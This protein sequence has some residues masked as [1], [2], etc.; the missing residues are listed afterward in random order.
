[1]QIS[2]P[3]PVESEVVYVR[4]SVN[5]LL[6]WVRGLVP[7]VVGWNLFEDDFAVVD[8]AELVAY[9][10]LALTDNQ[11]FLSFDNLLCYLM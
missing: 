2:F 8:V 10:L 1:M 9:G 7:S 11:Q 5:D 4:I 6:R 3:N